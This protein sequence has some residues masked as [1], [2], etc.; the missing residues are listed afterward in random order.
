MTQ[1]RIVER[2]NG[3]FEIQAKD[4][5]FTWWRKFGFTGAY[6]SSLNQAKISLADFTKG[7]S[8]IKKVHCGVRISGDDG[9]SHDN[10]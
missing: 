1:Y 6:Y 4:F 5:F 10:N 9:V 3:F 8:P 7:N 2:E